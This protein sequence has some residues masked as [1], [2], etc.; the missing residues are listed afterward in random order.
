[1]PK[2]PR[3]AA[4]KRQ[5][6][7]DQD[8]PLKHGKAE[9]GAPLCFHS[10]ASLFES[11]IRPLGTEEFFRDYWEKK[12]LH[13]QRS[14]ASTASCYQSLF[15][16]SDLKGLCSQGLEYGRDVNICRC[17]NGKKKVLNKDGRV[18][19]GVLHKDFV[20]NKA[21]IQFHQPQRFKDELWRIQE[22]LECFFG[23]L[24]GSNVYIT[25]QE[26]QGL[27]PHYDD[28]EVFILQLEGQKRWRLYSPTVPLAREYS[29]ESEDNI[30][31]PTHDIVLQT[32][33]LLYFPRG[34]IHQ[35]ETPVGMEHSTHLTLSTYQNLSWGDLLLDVFPGVLFD[36]SS[37]D[38]SLRQGIPRRLLLGSSE[39]VSGRLAAALRSLAD[40]METGMQE[41]R[42]SHLSRD[43][44]LSRL[45]PHTHTQQQHTPLG[46]LPALE[47]TVCLRFKDH[48]LITVEPSPDR[49]DE[50]TELVVF[51]L[52]SLKNQ[53]ESHM[54]GGSGDEEEEDDV[55]RGVRFPLSHLQ[56]LQ[57]LQRA[58]R[59][60]LADNNSK[61]MAASL[62]TLMSH[63][64]KSSKQDFTFGPWTVTAAKNHIMKS[65][66]IERLAEEMNMPSLPEMLFG[67]NVLRIQHAD[68]YGIE[69]NAI[70]AL[71][72][73]NN[74]EDAVKVACAQE[75]QESRVDSEHST[76]VLRP[77]DWT[78]TTDYRGTLIGPTAQ[79]QV[80]QTSERIDMEK[81]KAREQ[82]VFFE[83]V[84]L[85]EDELHDH[86]VS[87]ISVKIRVM[88]TSFFLLLRF[89]LRVDGVLIR[90]NDTRLY[91]E[92]G[93]NYMLREF[94]TRESK[95][96][97]LK[98]VPAAFYTDP[99][100][101]AQ[102]LTLRLTECDK[103]ELP[104]TPPPT[105]GSQDPQ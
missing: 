53:R 87:M 75:W 1:M 28:V 15:Q 56:A 97:E 57:Q 45:P 94:S 90:I 36:R 16:L 8:V 79:I 70:D 20:R 24:V 44:I 12:P 46:K 48:L 22:K 5:R 95:I 25:P 33:D 6:V 78:Y 76:E 67:D 49:T 105:A 38:V 47:D 85:F 91:H 84:L 18:N 59:L 32:G 100:E 73:V 65:K 37:T 27:P 81:L 34:T 50:A 11:L 13:L 2:K 101:I 74:M 23:A 29:L 60:A 52:H 61:L 54:M 42:S 14:E 26:S 4:V 88:P 72:R 17:I 9:D 93:K 103:L 35:A 64:F 7:D 102:H 62:S 98:N 82:I 40:Q 86:G 80:S 71:K 66:D 31:K 92:A 68:G 77:Y 99:N 51:V 19:Y 63:G 10:P 58:E 3:V 39:G 41:L 55:S 21:T 43:F 83:E 89:F 69:F 104:V 30:G 96:A